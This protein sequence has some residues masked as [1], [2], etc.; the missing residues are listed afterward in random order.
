VWATRGTDR[1]D[2]VVLI[3][4][5]PSRAETVTVRPPAGTQ[6]GA[7]L[8]RMQAPSVDSTSGVT[9]GGRTYGPSTATGQL[10]PAIT[11][12]LTP[13]RHG[14]YRVTVP[15]GSAALVTLSPAAR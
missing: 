3:D 10:A 1:I 11:R 9:L 12:A 13:N 4:K 5:D 8:E 14:N 7:T 15:A 6:T 2:R